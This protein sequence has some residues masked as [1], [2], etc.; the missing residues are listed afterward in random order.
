MGGYFYKSGEL[1]SG[2]GIFRVRGPTTAEDGNRGNTHGGLL[3]QFPLNDF[4]VK[5]RRHS[6]IAAVL[7]GWIGVE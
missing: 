2:R 7:T 6:D 5:E 1:T 3:W 4:R